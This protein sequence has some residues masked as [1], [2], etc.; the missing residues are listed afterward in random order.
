MVDFT[1]DQARLLDAL[2]S[3]GEDD[4]STT[5]VETVR[6]Y[7]S[8]QRPRPEGIP[9][10]VG[11]Y[12]IL[13]V[14]GQGGM[15]DVYSAR[16]DRLDRDVAIKAI[17]ADHRPTR[18]A[19][20]RFLQEARALS[21]LDHP[22]I[23][24]IYD[25]METPTGD[26]LVL[27]LIDGVSLRLSMRGRFDRRTKL[28]LAQQLTEALSAAHAAGVVHRDLKPENIMVTPGGDIKVLDFGLAARRRAD[29]THIG[30]ITRAHSA[31]ESDESD[32]AARS[33]WL[34]TGRDAGAIV[35]TPSYMSPEQARGESIT[36]ATDMYSLGLVLQELFTDR[37]PIDN[38]RNVQQL[39]ENAAN[40]VSLP[41]YGID[42]HLGQLIVRLK[43][44]APTMRPT[45]AETLARLR[46]V[47]RKP[48]RRVRYGSIAAVLAVI[49]FGAV[50]YTIDLGYERTQAVQARNDA[51]EARD[52]AVEARN[53]AVEARNDAVDQIFFMLEEL[54]EMEPVQRVAVL[55]SIGDQLLTY[56]DGR[57]ESALSDRE[58]FLLA[59]THNLLGQ[60]RMDE[61]DLAAAEVTFG[62]AVQLCTSLMRRDPENAEG[63][64]EL[65]AGEFHIGNVYFVR[66]D[67]DRTRRQWDI[68]FDIAEQLQRLDPSN[69]QWRMET[70][71]AY[72]SLGALAKAEGDTQRAIDQTRVAIELKR[73]LVDR[74]PDNA[75][76]QRD[77]ANS[78]SW[79]ASTYKS[80]QQYDEA[81]SVFRDELEIRR[82]LLDRDKQ[83]TDA[84]LQLSTCVSHIGNL[85]RRQGQLDDA[86]AYLS[87]TRD[88]TQSLVATDPLN[89][90]WRRAL[91]VA[92]RDLATVQ[93]SQGNV[94]EA[95]QSLRQGRD[96]L[97]P[98]LL[99]D[100][101]NADWRQQVVQ[102]YR[103]I[104]ALAAREER[105]DDANTEA[106]SALAVI[107][108]FLGDPAMDGKARHW[109]YQMHASQARA[110]AAQN[111]PDEAVAYW[112][113]ADVLEPLTHDNL[114][115]RQSYATALLNA[116][117]LD[118]AGPIV[119]DLIEQGV[120]DEAF[121][122]LAESKGLAFDRPA[123]ATEDD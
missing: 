59:K 19:R 107:E 115:D 55:N 75:S 46:W 63:L 34:P 95:V 60:V 109:S 81:M 44:A 64:A 18:A 12:R 103:G 73:E 25:Y 80:D 36:A 5:G 51:V 123:P 37:S 69:P 7:G 91:A 49:V 96:H 29:E 89:D 10:L 78:Y 58:L 85:L 108:P 101:T 72:A 93:A 112:S 48:A 104:V 13:R 105:W 68:Y 62:Q 9:D 56:F 117:R 39:I 52:D 40:A 50:K 16:D 43:S 8:E 106:Q 120:N 98:L 76:W 2:L 41:V 31:D 86:L 11:P 42:R 24:R 118:E 57:V 121:F 4:R 32:Q 82:G 99:K 27:E 70:A 38:A 100:P 23:C 77:L 66:N 1:P 110:A 17:R 122:D 26:F 45:A 14:L 28:K 84:R 21:S 20:E 35:G 90:R 114:Q 74:D 92:Y 94:S 83:D 88:L 47:Q 79:L 71:Y 65:G 102:L 87:E 6:L 113:A 22:G 119:R 111:K 3:D 116:D 30:E 53:D 97:E 61:G 33:L 54:V 15:G 67:Y